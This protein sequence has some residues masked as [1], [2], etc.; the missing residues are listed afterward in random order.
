MLKNIICGI[1]WLTNDVLYGK[2]NGCCLQ[3]TQ[4]PH[5]WYSWGLCYTLKG[6]VVHE[7]NIY[8]TVSADGVGR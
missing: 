2:R 8:P 4:S 3:V 6:V 7:E 1:L 5:D